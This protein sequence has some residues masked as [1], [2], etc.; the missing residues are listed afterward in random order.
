M[1]CENCGNE[2]NFL[3]EMFNK[4]LCNNCYNNFIAKY[5]SIVDRL[6]NYE[7]SCHWISTILTKNTAIMDYCKERYN[8]TKVVRKYNSGFYYSPKY[9]LYEYI[10][11]EITE[12]LFNETDYELLTNYI[13]ANYN[14]NEI[15]DLIC[16]IKTLLLLMKKDNNKGVVGY[17]DN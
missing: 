13:E 14:H 7:F 5:K 6:I 17:Y 1:E 4:I 8:I 10:K 3:L 2:T 15:K 11:S 16:D 12:N 9:K